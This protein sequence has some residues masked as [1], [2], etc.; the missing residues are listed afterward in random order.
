MRN[1]QICPAE[2]LLQAVQWVEKCLLESE[3]FYGHG[4]DNAWDEACYLVFHCCGVDHHNADEN[5]HLNAEQARAISE[6]L[7][8]RIDERLPA[9]YLT[10]KA[11]F[12]GLP[13]K[14][15][16]RV[17]VPRS[18]IAEL[19]ANEFSP[20][21]RA[22]PKRVLDLC[23][24]SGCIGIA[25]AYAFPGAE[26]LLSDISADALAV[27][28]DNIALH[29][30]ADRV[31][32]CESDGLASVPGKFDL[33]VS[34]PPYV[35][36]SDLDAMPAEFHAEPVLGLA[37]GNDGLDFTRELLSTAAT[38]LNDDG[39]LVCEVGNSWNAL[40]SAFPELPFIWMEL[41][42]GGHGVFVLTAAELRAHVEAQSGL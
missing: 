8:R 13:F 14:V 16:E 32:V 3:V 40:E 24:G 34:N 2:N 1:W 19:I 17:L 18:P 28:Q 29:E 10:G 23:T 41:E 37:S 15:D 26:V 6:L 35:D 36:Q 39:L 30:L 20:W 11:W 9:A 38:A 21:L 33:I 7:A 5:Q 4:T 42:Q 12:C 31:S 22:A 25:C 27:A